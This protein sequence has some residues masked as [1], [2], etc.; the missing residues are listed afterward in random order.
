MEDDDKTEKYAR[1]DNGFLR[2]RNAGE[3]FERASCQRHKQTC[4]SCCTTASRV[5]DGSGERAA[6]ILL[7]ILE[8]GEAQPSQPCLLHK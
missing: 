2:K 6:H 8:N 7:K 1:G 5:R 3:I 4:L